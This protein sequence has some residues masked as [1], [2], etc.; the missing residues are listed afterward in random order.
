M[1]HW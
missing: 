1:K